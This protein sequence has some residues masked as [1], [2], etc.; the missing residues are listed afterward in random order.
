MVKETTFH[1]GILAMT[2][3][4]RVLL[5]IIVARTGVIHSAVTM[6]IAKDRHT[7]DALTVVSQI[8]TRKHVTIAKGSSVITV[9][10]MVI[11]H[12]NVEI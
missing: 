11:K 12:V 2:R 5:R 10:A 6:E 8:I 3:N 9:M 7:P 1:I 4:N